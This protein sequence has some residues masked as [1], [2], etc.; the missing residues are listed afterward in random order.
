[1]RYYKW[2][3][4]F[5]DYEKVT[6]DKLGTFYIDQTRKKLLHEITEELK[7]DSNKKILI[8]GRFSMF[9]FLADK[10]PA[11]TVSNGR[12]SR[13]FIYE[14]THDAPQLETDYDNMFKYMREE[15]PSRIYRIGSIRKDTGKW[16]LKRE[17][18]KEYFDRFEDFFEKHYVVVKNVHD[19]KSG[20]VFQVFE[21]KNVEA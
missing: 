16:R 10:V 1:V 21:K 11:Y 7:R 14:Y 8:L 20:I 3:E 19:T 4:K 17:I 6:M 15:R 2:E 18:E 5:G 9:S 13:D 12:N